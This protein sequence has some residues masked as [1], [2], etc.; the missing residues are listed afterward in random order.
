[1]T[2]ARSAILAR[3]HGARTESV[4][5]VR[6]YDQIERSY[7]QKS[8]LDRK[9]ILDLFEDRLHDYGAKVTRCEAAEIAQTIAS[10]ARA[11]GKKLLLIP[12]GVPTEWQSG[13]LGFTVDEGLPYE[14]L[15]EAEGVVMGCALAIAETGTLVLRHNEQEGR[16]ALSLIPDYLLCV[17]RAEQVVASVVEG[18]RQCAAYHPLPITTISGPSATSD[19]EMTRIKG[20][21]G[22][23][24]LDV[25]L[26]CE[27][28]TA[29]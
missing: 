17:V 29:E 25:I 11:R 23:R 16:R 27:R 26:V 20:V 5:P 1:M 15:D 3:I 14:V 19:I 28:A 6:T 4:L 21:H 7:R 12:A 8:T 22:P 10:A 9:Q 2:N 18:I 13:G 24:I